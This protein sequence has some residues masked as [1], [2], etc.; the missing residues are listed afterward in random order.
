MNFYNRDDFVKT[1]QPKLAPLPPLPTSNNRSRK[2]VFS[3]IKLQKENNTIVHYSTA[4]AS[5]SRNSILSN[6]TLNNPITNEF[7]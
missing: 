7:R 1:P 2:A 6:S 3:K 4:D 5:K